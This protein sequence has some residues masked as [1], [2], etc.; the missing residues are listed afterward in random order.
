MAKS[1]K[2]RIQSSPLKRVSKDRAILGAINYGI[3]N[4]LLNESKE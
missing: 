3:V 2:K 4:R 1:E